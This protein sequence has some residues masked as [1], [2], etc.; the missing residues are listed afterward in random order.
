MPKKS[1]RAESQIVSFQ[2][3]AEEYR[4]IVKAAED[5]RRTTSEWIRKTLLDTL[6]TK[7]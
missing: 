2:C 4:K 7:G 5:D 3:T 1:S 6:R